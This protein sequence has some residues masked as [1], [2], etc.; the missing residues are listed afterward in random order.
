MQL[1]QSTSPHSNPTPDTTLLP[2]WEKANGFPLKYYRIGNSNHNGKSLLA[3][4]IDGIFND[5]ANFWRKIGA[6]LPRHS[7]GRDEL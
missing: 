2:K 4:E 5:R 1:I 3:M 7:L 6:H